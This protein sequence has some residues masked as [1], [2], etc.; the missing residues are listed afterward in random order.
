[1]CIL[2]IKQTIGGDQNIFYEICSPILL[3]VLVTAGPTYSE[4]PFLIDDQLWFPSLRS[5]S[6]LIQRRLQLQPWN[7]LVYLHT[8]L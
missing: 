2:Y 7:P 4:D 3:K 6:R 1:M 8:I 5:L